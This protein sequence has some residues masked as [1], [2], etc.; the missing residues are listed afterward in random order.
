MI[1]AWTT[2]QVRYEPLQYDVRY[3]VVRA[4][5]AFAAEL[6]D[7][8]QTVKRTDLPD[9]FL[10]NYDR[11]REA[12][13]CPKPALPL[14][15]PLGTPLLVPP[16]KSIE[17]IDAEKLE[18]WIAEN[19]ARHGLAF[20]GA[21]YT[22]F[23]LDSYTRGYLPKDGYHQYEVADPTKFPTVK[24]QRAWGGNYNF[25]FLDVGAAPSAWDY[26]PWANFTRDSAKLTER[27]DGPIWEYKND[28]ATFYSNLAQNVF[29]ATRILWARMPIYP[30]EYFEKYVLPI[31]VIVDPN[32]HTNPSSP[33]YRIQPADIKAKT[34]PDLIK[35]AFQEL[36]PWAD[37]QLE[38]KFIFLPGDDPALAAAVRDAKSRFSE[39]FVDYGI[40]KKYFTENWD[41]YVPQI[42]GARVY[43]TF[44]FVLEFPN[45]YVFAYSDGDE[46]GNSYGVFYNA[47]DSFLCGPPRRPVCFV[48]ERYA[49]PDVWWHFW[50]YI[51]V[52]E[53][54][55]SFGLTHPHDTAALD[56]DGYVTYVLNWLWDSTSSAMTYRHSLPTF[57]RFDKDLIFRGHAINLAGAVQRGGNAVP[58]EARADAERTFQLVREGKYQEAFEVAR[59]S[60][61]SIG[62]SFG[63]PTE[64][65]TPA[66]PKRMRVDLPAS[67]CPA[68]GVPPVYPVLYP[69]VPSDLKDAMYKEIPVEVPDGATAM[70]FEYRERNAPTH[71]RWTA[72]IDIVNSDEDSVAGLWYN[73]YDK[74]ILLN[75]DRCKGGCTARLYGVSGV[76]LSYDVTITPYFG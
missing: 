65:G 51:F 49:S 1:R 28:P 11:S 52:H 43:P 45:A 7:Y 41:K 56:E 59:S 68:G 48:E 26:R 62:D 76:N 36:A 9:V 27:I 34:D 6:F 53:L 58:A 24:S 17:R 30:F 55:H 39:N 69:C 60:Y 64:I 14:A 66:T 31:Y 8:A 46:L 50:N 72:Y 75:L 38:V 32:A 42:P 44:A 71:A 35:K 19:R 18:A 15:P 61:R 21:E 74:T 40:L 37:V 63:A 23:V 12:R 33:F 3:N 16:C 70:A 4:P 25:V 47:A 5:D 57:N 73:G 67:S 29:D 13:V 10:Q 2:G 20:E 54:G 22:L